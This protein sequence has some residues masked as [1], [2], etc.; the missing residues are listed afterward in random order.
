M[1]ATRRH[2]STLAT[3]EKILA[4][5]RRLF[6]RHGFDAVTMRKLAQAVGC[7]PGAIYVHYKDKQDVLRTLMDQDFS[8]F[9]DGM[10]ATN[11]IVDPIS[12]LRACGQGY[13]RFAL[14]HPHHYR[15]MF[16]TELP[17]VDPKRSTIEHGNPDCDG[18]ACLR[19]TVRACITTGRL[20][21]A[22]RD[23]ET[24]T[25]MCWGAAHGVVSLF[26]AHGDD[27][28][29]DFKDPLQTAFLLLD[30]SIDGMTLGAESPLTKRSSP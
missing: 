28:W 9:R 15:L 26:I 3:Q 10:T 22:Y 21:P 16:M 5:A 27:P 4:S 8:L 19:E 14:T 29:V 23:V 20:G 30:A 18:Y 2:L 24:V 12:R 25:Q 6:V 7:S 17:F 13:V 11:A 1:P